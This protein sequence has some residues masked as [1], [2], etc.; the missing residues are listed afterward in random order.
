M[1]KRTKLVTKSLATALAMS[2]FLFIQA[3]LSI[4]AFV[5]AKPTQGPEDC[6][7]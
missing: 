4:T 1:K 3:A 5:E 7:C 6:F 2:D